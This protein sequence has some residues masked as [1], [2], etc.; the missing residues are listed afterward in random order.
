MHGDDE[1]KITNAQ[2]EK[3]IEIENPTIIQEDMVKNVVESLITG[4]HLNTCS[5]REALETYRI[6]DNVLEKYYNGRDDEFWNR[7]K[8][9]NN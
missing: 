6:M 3:N 4:E 2:G 9:W 7:V 8:S 1:I 5:A